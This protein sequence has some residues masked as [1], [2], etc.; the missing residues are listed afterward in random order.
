MAILNRRCKGEGLKMK[1]DTKKKVS[2]LI[3]IAIF[4]ASSVTLYAFSGTT[5]TTNLSIPHVANWKAKVMIVLNNEV[6]T[7]P[8]GLGIL[9]TEGNYTTDKFFTIDTTN[10]IYKG[11][12]GQWTFNDL[13]QEMALQLIPIN[14]TLCLKTTISNTT[15]CG[16]TTTS[17]P[18]PQGDCGSYVIQNND[19]ILFQLTGGVINASG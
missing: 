2:A 15:F 10:E 13:L 12:E 3:V 11:Y 14:Q 18:C 6:Q 7:I 4:L 8:A 9:G 1:K 17:L 5:D 19:E 16:N